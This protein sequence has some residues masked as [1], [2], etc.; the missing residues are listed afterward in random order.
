MI[1]VQSGHLGSNTHMYEN[2][3]DNEQDAFNW[4]DINSKVMNPKLTGLNNKHNL[5][6]G[7]FICVH[8]APSKIV[9]P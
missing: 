8:P 3:A 9:L 6:F 4:V 1:S 5:C 2:T 7:V